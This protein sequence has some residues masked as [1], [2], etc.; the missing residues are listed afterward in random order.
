MHLKS[1]SLLRLCTHTMSKEFPNLFLTSSAPKYWIPCCIPLR[2]CVV[3]FSLSL[4]KMG[5]LFIQPLMQNKSFIPQLLVSWKWVCLRTPCSHH[6]CLISLQ[7]VAFFCVYLVFDPI[8]MQKTFSLRLV[9][10]I[11]AHILRHKM[12]QSA[13]PLVRQHSV[14]GFHYTEYIWNGIILTDTLYILLS[15]IILP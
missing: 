1:I 8:F 5:Y 11:T 2:S 15:T 13:L 12:G 3:S 4:G 9:W 10:C 6:G 14:V 7:L